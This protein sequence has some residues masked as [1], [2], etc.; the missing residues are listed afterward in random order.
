MSTALLLLL[1]PLAS[2]AEHVL[3]TADTTFRADRT[4]HNVVLSEA[5]VVAQLLEQKGGELRVRLGGPTSECLAQAFPAHIALTGWVPSSAAWTVLE[6][7]TTVD[8]GDGT[9]VH[10]AAGLPVTGSGK[11]WSTTG[12]GVGGLVV[13]VHKKAVGTVHDGGSP[14]PGPSADL[15]FDRHAQADD[16]GVIGQTAWGPLQA[17]TVNPAVSSTTDGKVVSQDPCR[18]VVYTGQTADAGADADPGLPPATLNRVAD[19]ASLYW[20]DGTLAGGTRAVIAIDDPVETGDKVCFRPSGTSVD[21]CTERHYFMPAK[22]EVPPPP[23]PA[24]AAPPPVEAT[25]TE[26]AKEAEEAK[27]PGSEGG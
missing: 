17:S 10:L 4:D 27:E 24:E 7:P 14:D 3:I 19:T 2:A 21:L 25:E 8:G 6:T 1:S 23:P 12:V 20:P 22:A 18:T 9:V 11:S 26:E 13:P 15:P 16:N 5:P